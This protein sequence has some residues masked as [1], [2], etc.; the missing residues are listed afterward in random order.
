MALEVVRSGKFHGA[1]FRGGIGGDQDEVF[2]GLIRCAKVSSLVNVT[3]VSGACGAYSGRTTHQMSLLLSPK[4]FGAV[5]AGSG[6]GC[7]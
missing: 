7:G 4:S 1:R 5:I 6:G 3:E 2:A